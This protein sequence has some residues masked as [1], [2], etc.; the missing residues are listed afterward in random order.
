[1]HAYTRAC[2]HTGMKARTPH[3]SDGLALFAQPVPLIRHFEAV[4]VCVCH[5]VSRRLVSCVRTRTP[6]S[7][8]RYSGQYSGSR[9]H[10][11]FCCTRLFAPLFKHRCGKGQQSQQQSNSRR[12]PCT[13]SHTHMSERTD[14]H[15]NM[16]SDIPVYIPNN[17]SLPRVSATLPLSSNRVGTCVNDDHPV[18]SRRSRQ[19]SQNISSR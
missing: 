5:G 4:F 19:L 1:M 11:C 16:K 2:A 17:A 14:K 13:R 6:A 7:S 15:E 8:D 9:E 3:K 12:Q 10:R 18:N